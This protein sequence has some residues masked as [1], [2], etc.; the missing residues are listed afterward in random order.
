[1][2]FLQK[3]GQVR[4]IDRAAPVTGLVMIALSLLMLIVHSYVT[5]VVDHP[6]YNLSKG[7]LE[8]GV[9]GL[10]LFY[11]GLFLYQQKRQAK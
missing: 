1:M 6:P 3:D 8:V 9:V 4:L 2:M 5:F 11:G 7:H 10:M